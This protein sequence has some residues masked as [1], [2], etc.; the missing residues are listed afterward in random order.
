[1]KSSTIG[2]RGRQPS[3]MMCT[4]AQSGVGVERVGGDRRE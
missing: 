3:V 4:Y 2:Y 1:V